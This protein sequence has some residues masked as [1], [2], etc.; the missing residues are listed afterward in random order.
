MLNST[1]KHFPKSVIRGFISVLNYNPDLHTPSSG[2]YSPLS[3]ALTAGLP[4]N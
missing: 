1:V 4:T 3:A 2:Q